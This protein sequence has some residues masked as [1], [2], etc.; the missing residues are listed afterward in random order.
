MGFF[1]AQNGVA[2]WRSATPNC[3]FVAPEIRQLAGYVGGA[4]GEEEFEEALGVEGFRDVEV[5]DLKFT[6]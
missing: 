3:V 2:D 5:A 4:E 6:A 1:R